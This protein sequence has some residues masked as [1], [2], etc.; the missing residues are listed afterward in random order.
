MRIRRLNCRFYSIGFCFLSSPWHGIDD[1]IFCF[2]IHV[3]ECVAKVPIKVIIAVHSKLK[4]VVVVLVVVV[5]AAAM[6]QYNNVV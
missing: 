5:M 2:S 6:Q 4:L 1:A 3:L